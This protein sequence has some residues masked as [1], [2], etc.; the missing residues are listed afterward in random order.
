MRVH[1]CVPNVLKSVLIG[2]CWLEVTPQGALG[3]KVPV[4]SPASSVFASASALKSRNNLQCVVATAT[5]FCVLFCFSFLQVRGDVSASFFLPPS[6]C[7]SLPVTSRW[8]D[9]N[10]I[11][12]FRSKKAHVSSLYFSALLSSPVPSCQSPDRREQ[13]GRFMAMMISS[14]PTTTL[15]VAQGRKL[16]KAECRISS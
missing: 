16:I 11:N 15:A 10:T 4:K 13:G 14:F 12:V 1:D 7:V 2:C 5:S 6:T 9:G 8:Q 3:N